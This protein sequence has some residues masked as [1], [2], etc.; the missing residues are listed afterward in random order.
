MLQVDPLSDVLKKV[1]LTGATFFDV[2]AAAPWVAEQAPRQ[3]VLKRIL[4]GAQHLI[5]YHVVVDGSCFASLIGGSP[6]R[7]EAGD[8]IVFANGDPHAISSH[9]GMR[10]DSAAA[11]P[12]IQ[13]AGGQLPYQIEFAGDGPVTAKLVCGF[14]ACDAQPF[15]PLLECLPQVMIVAGTGVNGDDELGMFS[16]L[17]VREA[18]T[19]RSGAEVVLAKLSELMFIEVVRRYVATL[20]PTGSGWL[21]GL[22]EPSTS[23]ALALLHGAPAKNWTMGEV[24]KQVGISRSVLYQRFTKLVGIP[25]MQYLAR[26]RMQVAAGL[27]SSG[28]PALASVA[29]DVGYAS[30]EAFSRAFKKTT[31]TSPSLWRGGSL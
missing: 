2:R 25:P 19:K 29:A 12:L 8:V 3:E 31:G 1:R 4:P 14:L 16:R 6:M 13:N 30:E 24:A 10:A 5:A 27:L 26:W 21:A 15:N 23:K 7:L 18:S 9:P 22:R 20:P 17:A 11:S 28:A